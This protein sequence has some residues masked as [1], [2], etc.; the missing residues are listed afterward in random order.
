MRIL[1]TQLR[2]AAA[3]ALCALAPAIAGAQSSDA[4]DFTVRPYLW[5][6]TINGTLRYAPPPGKGS[7]EVEMGPNDYLSHMNAGLMLSAEARKGDWA[8]LSDLI[9]L[10]MGWESSKVKQV[11]FSNAQHTGLSGSLDTG[12]ESSLKGLEWMLAASR[13]V[14]SSPRNRTEILGGVRYLGIEAS[15]EWRIRSTVSAPAGQRDFATRGGITQ[16]VNLVDAIVGVRGTLR[17][18]DGNWSVPYYLDVGAGDSSRTWQAMTGIAYRFNWGEATLAYRHVA[19]DQANDKML[20][21]LSF[22]GP[23]LSASFHF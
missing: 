23:A 21:S 11:S 19:Y 6:P 20:Q 22:S 12:T 1:H 9:Y 3:T 17:L 18:G 10:D 7:P 4:W 14:L 15:T 5:G 2:S 16:R 13:T 8:F